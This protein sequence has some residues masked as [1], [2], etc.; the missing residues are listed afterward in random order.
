MFV[1]A[2]GSACSTSSAPKTLTPPRDPPAALPL[3]PD[4]LPPLPTPPGRPGDGTPPSDPES[5]RSAASAVSSFSET[6]AP[7]LRPL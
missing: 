6:P 7:G 5:P 1:C 4:P 2:D 3:R